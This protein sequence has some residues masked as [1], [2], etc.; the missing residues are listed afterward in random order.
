MC[1]LEHQVIEASITAK[2]FGEH[3]SQK[4]WKASMIDDKG[5]GVKRGSFEGASHGW[6]V[7]S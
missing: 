7:A 2:A 4:G 5:A 1:R 3:L 6:S